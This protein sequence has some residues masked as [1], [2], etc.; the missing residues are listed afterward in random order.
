MPPSALE[1]F[2]TIVK[3]AKGRRPLFFLD[4]DGT[5]APICLHPRDAALPEKTRTVLEKLSGSYFTAVIS[6]RALKDIKGFLGELPVYIAGS[7]GFVIETDAGEVFRLPEAQGFRKDLEAAYRFFEGGLSSIPGVVLEMKDFSVAVHDRMVDKGLKPAVE[8]EV[9]RAQA[10]FPRLKRA[11]G[12]CVFE[13]KPL[14][15][16]DKGKAVRW[17]M[18][19]LPIKEGGAFPIVIGDDA[20][21]EDAFREVKSSGI[22]VFVMGEKKETHADFTLQSI[23]EVAEFLSHFVD[24]ASG[25]RA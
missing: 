4:Y 13:F 2:D 18:D 1:N 10:L 20:T 8:R 12:K 14:I 21:D 24:I 11:S 23:A 7:H 9:E 25:S 5:L 6:G 19:R 17:I 22:S 16:W 15:D 3:R